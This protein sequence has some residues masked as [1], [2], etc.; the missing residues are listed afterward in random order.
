M[1]LYMN[2]N[3]NINRNVFN[4]VYIMSTSHS[5][6]LTDLRGRTVAIEASLHMALQVYCQPDYGCRKNGLILAYL[7]PNFALGW[8][9]VLRL[10]KSGAINIV[11]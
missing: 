11:T 2:N 9:S 1:S 3:L 6:R 4:K 10:P 7:S 5:V 8:A